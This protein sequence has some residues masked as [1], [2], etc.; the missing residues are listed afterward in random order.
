M[1][2]GCKGGGGRGDGQIGCSTESEH[3]PEQVEGRASER[4]A[5]QYHFCL[6]AER[7]A[8]VKTGTAVEIPRE[9]TSSHPESGLNHSEPPRVSESKRGRGGRTP[10]SRKRECP[11]PRGSRRRARERDIQ[12]NGRRTVR[13]GQRA[14][15]KKKKKTQRAAS[16]R[17][18]RQR[19]LA[20]A[21]M[22][23]GVRARGR[24]RREQERGTSPWQAGRRVG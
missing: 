1:R 2:V 3:G 19:A 17:E 21:F 8:S 11:R 9:S 16:G 10:P 23:A 15:Q 24:R 22:A 4:A 5:T 12:Q 20:F 7:E 18:Q 14:C 13:K 6:A